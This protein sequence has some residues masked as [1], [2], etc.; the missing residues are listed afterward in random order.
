MTSTESLFTASRPLL[1]FDY[2]RVP[3]R[4]GPVDRASA[5]L[6]DGVAQAATRGPD[7]QERRLLWVAANE[8][9]SGRRPAGFYRLGDITLV[10]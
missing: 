4:I 3:Y 2:F 10:G 8:S 6:P 7:G 1:F 5:N 9:V